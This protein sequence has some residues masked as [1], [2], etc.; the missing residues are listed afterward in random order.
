MQSKGSGQ[1]IPTSAVTKKEVIEV[2]QDP[3]LP[4]TLAKKEDTNA[5][6]EMISKDFKQQNKWFIANVETEESYKKRHECVPECK[7]IDAP[8]RESDNNANISKD[9]VLPDQSLFEKRIEPLPPFE[10]LTNWRQNNAEKS[11][12]ILP[13]SLP[14]FE[15]SSTIELENF[16]WKPLI[17]DSFFSK[18]VR[19]L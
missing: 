4:K 3:T 19:G 9:F 13:V 8:I 16:E 1:D 2:N 12:S 14:K 17:E 11:E 5:S 15:L 6:I 10:E 7:V 18:P